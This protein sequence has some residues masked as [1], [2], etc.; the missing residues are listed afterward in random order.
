MNDDV[1]RVETPLGYVAVLRLANWLRHLSRRPELAGHDRNVALTLLEPHILIEDDTL[2]HHYY[3]LGFGTGRTEGTYLHVLVRC[4][5]TDL[6]NERT[7][8]TAWFTSVITRGE[9]LWPKTPL[10]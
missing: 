3:R 2:C 4:F 7:V 8:V 6:E 10:S 9:L 1:V 5:E